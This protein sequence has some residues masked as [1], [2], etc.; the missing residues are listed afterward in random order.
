MDLQSYVE[1]AY[2]FIYKYQFILNAYVIVGVLFIF[3]GVR[4]VAA[5]DFKEYAKTKKTIHKF[6]VYLAWSVFYIIFGSLL[7]ISSYLTL[8]QFL[9]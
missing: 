8:N 1:A 2:A 6:D 9:N 7:I 5:K 3:L 4:R